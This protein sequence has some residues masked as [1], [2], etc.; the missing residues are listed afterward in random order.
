MTYEILIFF[1]ALPFVLLRHFGS[2]YTHQSFA[3]LHSAIRIFVSITNAD[4]R[5]TEIQ[6]FL[7]TALY[8]DGLILKSENN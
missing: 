4:S 2:C 7:K 1:W 6:F 5:I 8:K 3:T